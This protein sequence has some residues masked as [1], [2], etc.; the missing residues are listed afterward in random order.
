MT[1][2]KHKPSHT[3]TPTRRPPPERGSTDFGESPS[4]KSQVW[5]VANTMPAPANPNRTD[6][7]K[8]EQKK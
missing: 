3:Q 7:T 2:K 8:V 1:D 4:T 5:D 6:N